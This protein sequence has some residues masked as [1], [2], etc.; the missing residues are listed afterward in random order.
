M[1]GAMQSNRGLSASHFPNI[2]SND[3]SSICAITIA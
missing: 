2:G 1:A 3:I